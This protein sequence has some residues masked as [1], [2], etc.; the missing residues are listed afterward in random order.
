MSRKRVFMKG[1]RSD[2]RMERCPEPTIDQLVA[3]YHGDVYRYAFRLSG[4]VQDAEDLCQQV[5][6]IAQQRLNQLRDPRSAR[7][8]LLAITRSQYCRLCRRKRPILAEDSEV[9][10]DAI[11]EEVPEE[12]DAEALELAL[13]SLDNAHRTVLLMFYI[14]QMSYRSMAEELGVPIGT[15]MSRL[16][17]A[18]ARLRQMVLSSEL[19]HGS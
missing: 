4:R 10:L 15:V 5:F 12:I 1:D 11:A 14:E 13:A 18:K 19:A 8:W 2:G 3:H 17:R 16:S 6:L 9:A 7:A